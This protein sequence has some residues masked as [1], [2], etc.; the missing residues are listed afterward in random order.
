MIDKQLSDGKPDNKQQAQ[1]YPGG[2]QPGSRQPGSRQPSDKHSGDMQASQP[3]YCLL[4]CPCDVNLEYAGSPIGDNA[5]VKTGNR[6]GNT[7]LPALCERAM[8]T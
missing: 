6:L 5:V 2:K 4:Q 1:K 7:K 3:A 8:Y